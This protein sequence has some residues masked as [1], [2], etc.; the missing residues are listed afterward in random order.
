MI[1]LAQIVTYKPPDKF[2][3]DQIN[4]KKRI[5]FKKTKSIFKRPDQY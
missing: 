3:S 2:F 5:N 4:F 1:K